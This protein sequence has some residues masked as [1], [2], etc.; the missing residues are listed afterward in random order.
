M[1]NESNQNAERIKSEQ[2]AQILRL[3]NQQEKQRELGGKYGFSNQE[4][5]DLIAQSILNTLPPGRR[6]EA[7]R[8]RTTQLGYENDKKRQRNELLSALKRKTRLG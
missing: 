5:E 4:I 8:R 3:A 7:Q 6:E 2:I 1:I